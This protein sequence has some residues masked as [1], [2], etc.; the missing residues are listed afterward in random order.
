MSELDLAT[1]RV[2]HR[3]GRYFDLGAAMDARQSFWGGQHQQ[4]E[5]G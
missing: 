3:P 1:S 2:E 5:R 4:P